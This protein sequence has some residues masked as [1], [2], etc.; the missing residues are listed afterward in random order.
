MPIYLGPCARPELVHWWPN[1]E[2]KGPGVIVEEKD[3]PA[4]FISWTELKPEI[5]KM[6][7]PQVRVLPLGCTVELGNLGDRPNWVM[8]VLAQDGSEAAHVWLG[9][10]ADKSWKWDGLV[11]VGEPNKPDGERVWQTFQRYSDGTYRRISTKRVT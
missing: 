7:L 5:E 1:H 4:E 9:N 3:G 11:R 10:N 8:K 2:D 6:L